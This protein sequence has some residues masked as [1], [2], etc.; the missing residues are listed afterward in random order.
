M[1]PAPQS[2]P[3]GGTLIT[4]GI[5]GIHETEQ[6]AVQPSLPGSQESHK[7]ATS[8]MIQEDLPTAPTVSQYPLERSNIADERRMTDMG[9]NTFNVVIKPTGSG[10][11]P[12][13]MEANV[14]TSLPIVDA[15]LPFSLGDHVAISYVNLSI[16]G[17]E[18]DSL[19]TSGIR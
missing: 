14:Q 12:L 3:M 4:P 11:R 9:T 13:H 19:R 5:E 7:G 15:L 18:P 17:Y 10:P 16:S 2:V 8:H 6:A 1:V